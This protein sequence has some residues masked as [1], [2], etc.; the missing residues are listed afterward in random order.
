EVRDQPGQFLDFLVCGERQDE[1]R[2]P[3]GLKLDDLCDLDL[4][5]L[6]LYPRFLFLPVVHLAPRAGE[7]GIQ[8]QLE[9][10]VRG[11]LRELVCHNVRG[12]S[13][14]PQPSPRKNGEREKKYYR[15]QSTMTVPS[16]SLFSTAR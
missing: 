2:V 15:A 4:A 9:F 11:S 13:P 16:L 5:D 12:W 8:A 6:P 14:S 1:A 10:R 3:Q 7:V